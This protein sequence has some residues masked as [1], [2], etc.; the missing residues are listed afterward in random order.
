MEQTIEDYPEPRFCGYVGMP[1]AL[2]LKIFANYIKDIFSQ[3]VYLVGS[4]LSKKDWHDLDIVVIMPDKIW[5][6]YKF[7]NPKIDSQTRSGLLIVWRYQILE[8]H[9]SIVK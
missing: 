4:S 2:Y 8:N 9:C 3:D 5:D 1:R 6:D 7:G